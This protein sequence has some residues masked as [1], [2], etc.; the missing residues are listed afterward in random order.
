[1]P[2]SI[3]PYREEHLKAVKAFNLRL[4][5]GTTDP[6]LV[7]YER[8]QPEWLPPFDGSP[9]YNQY[10][11]ALE[12]EEVRGAYALKCERFFLAEHGE[13]AVACYH[14]PLSE[15]IVNRKYSAVGSLL[16][17]DALGREP[18]LYALG[19]GG[20]DGPLAKMLKVMGWSLQL[21]PFF[22][23]VVH[24][25]RFFRQMNALRRASWRRALMDLAAFSGTGWLAIN[26]A[27]SAKRLGRPIG[28]FDA[29]EVDEFPSRTDDLWLE[30]KDAYRLTSVR[31][32]QTIARLY[33]AGDKHLTKLCVSRQGRVIGW[34]V[35]GERRK[36]AKFGSLR[37]GSIVDCWAHPVNAAAVVLAATQALERHGMD[38]VVSNQ[39]HKA[40]CQALAGCG[41]FQA[42]SNF[43][44]AT[45][46]KLSALLSGNLS[47]FHLNRANGDGLPRN[48]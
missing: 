8:A 22:F 5:A 26:A 23:R 17:R 46:K 44:F 43:L 36:D 48:F 11:V 27:Q 45:S 25:Y 20:L 10:F 18:M 6:N 3:Q 13:Y 16:L 32:H 33:P 9:L 24:P 12:S 41:F 7:F 42:E 21:V 29:V 19:M 4:R 40:W 30:A 14:H 37:V 47:D 2:I 38:L 34:A 1:M 15:G 39:A 28:P 31:D 35:V